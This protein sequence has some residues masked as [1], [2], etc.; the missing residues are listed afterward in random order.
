MQHNEAPDVAVILE[1]LRHEL[2][3]QRAAQGEAD[4]STALGAIERELQHCAEQLEI[5]RV[6]SAHW[7]LEG[8]TLYQRG[9]VLI[10]KV[11]RRALR[12]YINPIVEQQNAFNA[13]AARSLHLLIEAHADLRDQLAELQRRELAPPPHAPPDPGQAR[14]HDTATEQ[15]QALIERQGRAEVRAAL[16]DLGLRPWPLRL[17]ELATVTAHWPLVGTTPLTKARALAQRVLRQYLRW[18]INPI[19][20]Q[21]NG[22]NAAI[23]A[24]LPPLLAADGEL[25][26]RLAALRSRR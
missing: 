3:A 26:A 2:R 13:A 18:M 10:N 6:V 5:T 14:P 7:P 16:P 4:A 22:A 9:W 8:R 23:H 20:E 19:V 21:Q 12:W 11:V 17:R 25:R 15:L 1:Q 24:A